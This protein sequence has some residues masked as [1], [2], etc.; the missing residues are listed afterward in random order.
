MD[1]FNKKNHLFL[2]PKF[3]SSSYVYRPI[4]SSSLHNVF[5]SPN[6]CSKHSACTIKPYSR[7]LEPPLLTTFWYEGHIFTNLKL[8]ASDHNQ[9]QTDYQG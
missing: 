5:N 1:R 9:S 4:T 7:S 2:A 8:L 3:S 6:V